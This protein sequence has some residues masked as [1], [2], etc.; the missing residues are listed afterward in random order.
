MHFS[1][2]IKDMEP[3]SFKVYCP[4]QFKRSPHKLIMYDDGSVSKNVQYKDI[5][6]EKFTVNIAYSN[7]PSDFKVFEL[8]NNSMVEYPLSWSILSSDG[9][10]IAKD[11]EILS[12]FFQNYNIITNWV[13]CNFTWGYFDHVTG[14]WTGGVGKVHFYRR[15][16]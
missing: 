6:N 13:D 7:E 14:K 10:Y 4:G 12:L 8:V 1:K 3:R 5:C 9:S 16:I 15:L 2:N 11:W